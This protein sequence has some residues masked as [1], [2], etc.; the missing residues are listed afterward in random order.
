MKN[1]RQFPRVKVGIFAAKLLSSELMFYI[2]WIILRRK[3]SCV[4]VF[5][6]SVI[7][8]IEAIY[9]L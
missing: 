4:K 7:L 5:S 2:V 1:E 6:E 8:L 3:S 9:A